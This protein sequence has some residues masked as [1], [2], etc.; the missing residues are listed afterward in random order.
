MGDVV[1]DAFERMDHRL[2]FIEHAVDDDREPGKRLVDVAI[3]QPLAQIAGDDALDPL[4]DL[5]DALLGAHAQPRA[6]QQAKQKGGQQAERQR[7]ADDVGDLARLV[8]FPADHQRVAIGHAA[9]DRADHAPLLTGRK[10]PD[11]RHVPDDIVHPEFGRNPFEIARDSP[12]AGIEQRGILNAAGIL[13]Q[14][15]A[16]GIDP[17]IGGQRRD[18]VELPRDHVVGSRDKIIV[19][20]PVD[21]AEQH[22][23]EDREHGGNRERPVKGVRAYEL[24]LTHRILPPGCHV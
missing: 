5:L 15:L 20:L 11:D 4:V 16:D 13:S 7:L 24:R 3:R 1:A 9:G 2:H 10:R 19:G 12:P 8:D 23:D 17:A 6:G 22:D 18:E 14:M 21:E